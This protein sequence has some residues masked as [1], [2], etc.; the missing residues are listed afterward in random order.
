MSS[1]KALC[2]AGPRINLSLI[3]QMTGAGSNRKRYWPEGDRRDFVQEIIG[4]QHWRCGDHWLHQSSDGSYSNAPSFRSEGFYSDTPALLRD[5]GRIGRTWLVLPSLIP[6]SSYRSDG[7]QLSRK[8]QTRRG[9]R[10][11]R[12]AARQPRAQNKSLN[13]RGGDRYNSL[14]HE[15][16]VLQIKNRAGINPAS[17]SA[18][19]T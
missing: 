4:W 15:E 17:L 2:S 16:S 12:N 13:K 11:G 14:L 3:G 1:F 18:Q 10:P 5:R 6:A 7:N 8:P 19:L 9:R